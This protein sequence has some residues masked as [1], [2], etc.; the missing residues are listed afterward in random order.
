VETPPV[1]A[2]AGVGE[3]MTLGRM[4]RHL[5]TT[6]RKLL[7]LFPPAVLAA[8]ETEIRSCEMQHRG[9]I[10]FAIEAA[11]DVPELVRGL[12]P[13]ARTQH[14]FSLLRV[15]DTEANNGVL[16]YLLLAD[17]RVEIVADRGIARRVQ[18]SEWEEI[19]R[20]MERAFRAGDFQGGAISGIRAVG[21]LLAR[22]FPAQGGDRNE[23]PDKPVVL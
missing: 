5:F 12:A 15:W 21:D 22:H 9:E 8:I 3:A 6:R 10:R 7:R 4:C 19:C 14:V 18:Q 23:L 20:A 16:I 13:R 17:R 11:L 1:A 2:R